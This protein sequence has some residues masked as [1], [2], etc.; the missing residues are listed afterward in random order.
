MSSSEFY[1]VIF[2]SLFFVSFDI[3]TYQS[4]FS[5]CF[6]VHG[7]E[8]CIALY[9]E[10]R[11]ET[12][13]ML[14]CWGMGWCDIH[15]NLESRRPKTFTSAVWVA[16]SDTRRTDASWFR[17]DPK[18]TLRPTNKQMTTQISWHEES[19]GKDDEEDRFGVVVVV[20]IVK[21]SVKGSTLSIN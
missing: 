12:A 20:K 10:C 16:G 14:L 13:S 4:Y 2:Q 17:R 9:W 15:R 11:R 1:S 8:Y 18:Y 3:S 7:A 21:L 19:E 6:R 5:F